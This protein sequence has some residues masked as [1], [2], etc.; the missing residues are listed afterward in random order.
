MDALRNVNR[1]ELIGMCR[2]VKNE[3]IF[4]QKAKGSNDG[5]WVGTRFAVKKLCLLVVVVRDEE[6]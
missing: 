1:R 4:L 6:I 3:T 2:P 5:D